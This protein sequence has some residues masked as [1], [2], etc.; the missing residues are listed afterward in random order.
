MPFFYFYPLQLL[1]LF[2]TVAQSYLLSFVLLSM[3]ILI[4][5]LLETVAM[6]YILA[7]LNIACA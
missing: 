1:V 6:T 4:H 3:H 2:L 5:L 7:C